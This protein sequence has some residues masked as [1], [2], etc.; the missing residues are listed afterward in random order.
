MYKTC[1]SEMKNKNLR[2]GNFKNRFNG[3]V[4]IQQTEVF[5]YFC[6]MTLVVLFLW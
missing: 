6:A 3:K 4:K 1:A 5:D 2:E